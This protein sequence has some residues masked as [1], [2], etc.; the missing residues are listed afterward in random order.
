MKPKRSNREEEEGAHPSVKPDSIARDLT[1][2][3]TMDEGVPAIILHQQAGPS[4]AKRSQGEPSSPLVSP[5]QEED[6]RGNQ[7]DV[8]IPPDYAVKRSKPTLR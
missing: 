3:S 4:D 6:Q 8:S 2:P 1:L 7:E 5:S